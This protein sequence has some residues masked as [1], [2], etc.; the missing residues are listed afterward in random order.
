MIVHLDNREKCRPRNIYLFAFSYKVK[1]QQC[2][3]TV[4]R[5]RKSSKYLYVDN[6]DRYLEDS[7]KRKPFSFEELKFALL[8]QLAASV[9]VLFC[10]LNLR[11]HVDNSWRDDV[12]VK[13]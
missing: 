1:E 4:K 2:Q 6:F 5:E 12:L 3:L 11:C 10:Q 7:K 9:I 8:C 13:Y